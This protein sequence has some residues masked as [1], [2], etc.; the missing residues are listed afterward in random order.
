MKASTLVRVG[1]RVPDPFVRLA[2]RRPTRRAVVR[3]IFTRMPDLL[4]SA[5]RKANGIIRFDVVDDTSVDTWYVTFA[6]GRCDVSRTC[7]GAPRA[8]IILSSYDF[9]RLATGADAV[10]MFTAGKLRLSGD[11]YFGASVGG[12]FDLPR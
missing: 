10:R 2:T 9:V 12:L 11:T 7:P 3:Q 8:T 6:G 1:R 4:S 5:G